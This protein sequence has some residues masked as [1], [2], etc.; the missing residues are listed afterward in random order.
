MTHAVLPTSRDVGDSLWIGGPRLTISAACASGLNA[1]IRATLLIR[2]REARRVMVVAAESSF[3]PLFL[4]SF[5]RL[6]VVAPNDF[7]CRPFDR[8]RQGFLMSEAAAAVLLESVEPDEISPWLDRRRPHGHGDRPAVIVENFAMGGDG[9]HLTG[10]DPQSRVLRRLLANVIDG[11]PV[12]MIHAHGTGT[13]VNDE[14]ELAAIES[15]VPGVKDHERRPS[16]YSHKG[17]AGSQPGA[18]G[19]V[20]VAINCLSHE[21]WMVP[22]N[23]RTSDPLPTETVTISQTPVKRKVDRS[24]AMAAGFG[25]TT[26]VISLKTLR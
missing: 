22:P 10:G 1:L 15:C 23:A 16:L 11:K 18:A 5:R 21:T 26:A 7:G 8:Q 19:L 12:D 24:I 3:H 9:G 6:G 13:Q 4:A 25:G 2:S 14:A 20:A 17:G